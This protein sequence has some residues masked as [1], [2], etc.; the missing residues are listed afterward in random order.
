MKRLA[1]VVLAACGGGGV[2]TVDG[3]TTHVDADPARPD[4]DPT[5]PD[6]TPAGPHLFTDDLPWDR[7]V[8][9]L[10]PSTESTAI[11]DA[12]DAAGGWGTGDFRI[13]MS[14]D[15]QE[16]DASTPRVAFTPKDEA[17]A[18]A[19]LGD[20]DLAEFYRPDC[21]EVPMP[22]PVGGAVEGESGYACT[23]DGDCHLIVIDRGART[24]FEMWRADRPGATLFGGCTARWDLDANYDPDRLRGRG[25]S[26]ADAG[27]FPIAAMLATADEVATGEV[28]HALRFILPNPRIRRGI[29]VPPATHS[30]F[31]TNGGANMPPYGVRLRLR[32]T[33]DERTLPSDGARVLA[34]ALKRYGMFLADGGNLP[35]TIASDRYATARWDDLGVDAHSLSALRATDFEVVEYRDPVDWRADTTCVRE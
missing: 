12:L 14:I 3:R 23:E 6:A 10:A 16:A 29:Y 11:I 5:R 4:A 34:R 24:L 35:L 19:N 1:L 7:D 33:F 26:S 30:T 18:E 22:L 31:P 9:G 32:A 8:S 15:I 28:G 21:D 13:D 2:G 27:G 17:W 25:C 20:A